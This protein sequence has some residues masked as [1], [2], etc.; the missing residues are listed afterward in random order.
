M[1]NAP[2]EV[3]T[4]APTKAPTSSG[5]SNGSGN[6]SS[7]GSSSAAATGTPTKA[8]TAAPTHS[9]TAAGVTGA[10]TF[11]GYTTD[12]FNAVVR[13]SFREAI[14][15]TVANGVTKDDV[16]ILSVTAASRRLSSSRRLAGG[17]EI[18]YTIAVADQAAVDAAISAIKAVS[19]DSAALATFVAEYQSKVSDNNG[20]PVPTGF[21]VTATVPVAGLTTSAPTAAPTAAPT[22]SATDAGDG[23]GDDGISPASKASASAL[24]S[25]MA[26]A[27]SCAMLS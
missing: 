1:G 23:D 2:T 24:V 21:T 18:S 20:D 4:K 13:T 12:T 15:A 26:L 10:M 14:A 3:P 7:N 22:D 6:G 25:A 8:P 17:V 11:T 5:S 9:P 19:E 16:T 27:I